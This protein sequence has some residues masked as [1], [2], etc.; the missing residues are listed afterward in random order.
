MRVYNFICKKCG[1]TTSHRGTFNKHITRKTQ[2][3]TLEIEPR[4]RLCGKLLSNIF[5]L[6]RHES[7]KNLHDRKGDK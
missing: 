6:K 7:N 2:C 3:D 1:Y 5:S 4:C